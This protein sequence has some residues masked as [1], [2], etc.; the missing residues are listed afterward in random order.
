MDTDSFLLSVNG[1][2]IVNN[3]KNLKIL[4]EFS[5]IN[6]NYSL[7]GYENKKSSG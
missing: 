6:K 4:L 2:D 1:K 5:D 7:F 3:L